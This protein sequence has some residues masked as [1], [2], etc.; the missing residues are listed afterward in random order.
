[1]METNENKPGR[2]ALDDFNGWEKKRMKRNQSHKELG[3][4]Q[5]EEVAC[6]RVI[7][8][9]ACCKNQSMAKD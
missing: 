3:K 8:F 2:M 4:E 9:V 7:R 1:V 6:V 5:S